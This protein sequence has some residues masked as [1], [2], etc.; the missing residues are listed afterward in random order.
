VF[1]FDEVD[2]MGADYRGDPSA[3]ML[4]VLD[5]EQNNTFRDNYME[6]PFD[7]SQVLFVATANTAEGIPAPL[8]DRMEVIDLES[9]TDEEKVQI[10]RRHLLDKQLGEH[11]LQKGQLQVSDDMLRSI[12]RGYTREAGVRSLERQIAAL[13]RKTARQVAGGKRKQVRVTP[14]NLEKLLGPVRF[15]PDDPVGL[16]QVGIATGLAWTEVGGETLSIEVNLMPGDGKLQLTG[17]LGDVMKESAAAALSYI[18]AHCEAL[19]INADFY[20]ELDIHIHVPQGATPK[21][22]PSAGITMATA[23]IS[24]LRG[25]P[26]RPKLAMTGEITLRGKVL[27]IGGLKEKTMAAYRMGIT[28]V[29][30]PAANAPD[31]QEIPAVVRTHVELIP[32]K[33][34]DEVAQYAFEV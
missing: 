4:E 14:A 7:L 3:A 33:T 17:S 18:R 19:Q 10:A 15:L 29:L 11:G 27:P 23:L 32:V 6:F 2:K 5:P 16:G 13:C 8:Y 22:G 31:V 34:M 25:Q 1:L 26:V 12:I 9:Y 28:R 20:K 21:D 24:A 30:Y